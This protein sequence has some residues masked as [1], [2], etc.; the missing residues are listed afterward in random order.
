MDKLQDTANAII[1]NIKIQLK[2][3]INFFKLKQ[4]YIIIED[5]LQNLRASFHFNPKIGGIEYKSWQYKKDE[6]TPY[7]FI[8]TDPLH[9]FMNRIEYYKGM[10]IPMK[11]KSLDKISQ[12]CEYLYYNR[13]NLTSYRGIFDLCKQKMDE[14][15]K[16]LANQYLNNCTNVI[17]GT[18]LKSSGGRKKKSRKNSHRKKR[19]THKRRKN[20]SRNLYR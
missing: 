19:R 3:I 6:I 1:H 9:I 4:G 8:K 14:S 7:T 16:K 12:H 5:P 2:K 11:D 13:R 18:T 15:K 17:E 10:C 20:K